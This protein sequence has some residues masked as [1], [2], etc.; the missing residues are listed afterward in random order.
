MKK[1]PITKILT[2]LL[3]LTAGNIYAFKDDGHNDYAITFLN[4]NKLKNESRQQYLRSQPAWTD[5]YSR[6]QGWWVDFDENN[7]MPHRAAGKAIATGVFD[8]ATA[9]GSFMSNELKSFIKSTVVLERTGIT[10]SPKF[11]QVNY[12][13]MFNGMEVLFT[14]ATVKLTKDNEVL[15]FGLDIHNDI[16]GNFSAALSETDAVTFAMHDF[17]SFSPIVTQPPVLKILP[18]TENGNYIYKLVYELTV[19][20]THETMPASYYS[21]VDANDGKILYRSNKIVQFSPGGISLNVNGT[22]YPTHPYNSTTTLPLQYVQVSAGSVFNADVNGFVALPQGTTNATIS[23]EGLFAKVY[24][25]QNG[26]TIQSLNTSVNAGSNNVSFDPSSTASHMSAYHHTNVVHDFMKSH[27]PTFTGL[28]FPIE[29]R[30]ERTD[31]NCN[32]FYN[33]G[34][35]FYSLANGCN[36]LSLV[37]D[38]VYHEYGHGICYSFYSAN[39]AS[40]QNGAMGEGYA[41]VWAISITQN[42]VLG[43]GFD[44]VDPTVFVRNYDFVN[45]ANRKVYPQNLVGEVHSD[46]EIICGAWWDVALNFNSVPSMAALFAETQ[47]GLAN[48]PDGSEGQVYTDVLIDALQADDNDNDLLNGTPNATAIASAFAL[49]GITLL[50]NANLAHTQV[51]ASPANIPVTINADLTNVSLAFAWAFS[52]VNCSYAINNSSTW[53]TLPM[54]STN[55]IN[56]TVDIPAQSAGTVVKYYVFVQDVNGVKSNVK[57]AGADATDPN[58]PYFIRV[59]YNL[60]FTDDFD[61]NLGNWY[62][63]LPG[64][65]ATSGIWDYGTPVE[66]TVNGSVVQT[67]TQI[68]PGGSICFFTGNAPLGTGAGTNDVDGGKTTLELQGVDLSAYNN[69]IIEYY[70]WYSNDQGATPGTDAWQVLISDDGGQTYLPVEN[71]KVA[72][73][74]WRNFVF[75]VADYVTPNANVWMQFIAEDANA[76]SLVEALLDEFSV[77]EEAVTSVQENNIPEFRLYP[78]PADNMITV[79]L[80]KPEESVITVINVTGETVYAAATTAIKNV[81]QIPTSDMASGVYLLKVDGVNTSSSKRFVVQH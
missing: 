14:R 52:G 72:D 36:P 68:T 73:H 74:S 32:A 47:Y 41:D 44:A 23:L 12:K 63:G 21:L 10:N 7:G 59:G 3:L 43:V 51:K 76:G 37:S 81:I 54:T 69:P 75:R 26:T 15:M 53:T 77:Y 49:H 64:D 55:G 70:R 79:K 8:P 80:D 29:I 48:G 2:I 31:G 65:N 1:S 19:N 40:F 5:F 34:L 20:C 4:R 13:Q 61:N 6:H 50:S 35:N 11:N 24:T 78:N 60:L 17:V 45:G 38:V 39:G 42:P 9:A 56:Y 62:N 16:N 67:S 25:G 71:T 27:Y 28:D 57:P 30:V 46:G 22:I 66:S 58:I 18:V 33:G